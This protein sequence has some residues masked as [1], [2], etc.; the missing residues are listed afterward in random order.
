MGIITVTELVH[1]PGKIVRVTDR[2][3]L[4]VVFAILASAASAALPFDHYFI[5]SSR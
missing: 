2:T 4:P 3:P 1:C 5:D